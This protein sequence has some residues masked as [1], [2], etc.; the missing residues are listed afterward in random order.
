MYVYYAY[1]KIS[2]NPKHLPYCLKITETSVV[3]IVFNGVICVS[4]LILI[5]Y[6]NLHE[7]G[8]RNVLLGP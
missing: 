3:L 1:P 2:K 5:L 4:G 6:I 8:T 7:S